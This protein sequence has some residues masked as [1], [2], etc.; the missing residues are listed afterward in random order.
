[1]NVRAF[2]PM[3]YDTWSRDSK[4]VQN[5]IEAPYRY[6]FLSF[7]AGSVCHHT[8][9]EGIIFG[10]NNFADNEKNAKISKL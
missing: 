1:M 2:C 6:S 7:L 3:V 4:T 9:F 10:G 8:I 5:S